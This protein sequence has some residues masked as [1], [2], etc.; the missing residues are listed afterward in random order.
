M[1][2]WNIDREFYDPTGLFPVHE[3][4]DPER[5]QSAVIW[6]HLKDDVV[7]HSSQF[8]VG[9]GDVRSGDRAYFLIGKV[10]PIT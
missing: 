2:R 1:G 8:A 9:N 4:L 5:G 7:G 10:F 6:R 3:A